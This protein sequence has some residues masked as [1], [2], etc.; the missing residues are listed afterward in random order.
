[1]DYIELAYVHLATIFPAFLIG[2]FLLFKRK[3]TRFHKQLGKVYMLLMLFT[4]SVTLLMPAE[5]GPTFLN[6]FGFIHLLSLLVFICVI[7]A[8]VA[9]RNGNIKIHKANML[10]L[11]IGGLLVAGGFTFL[12]GR[13]LNGWV[14]G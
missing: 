14:F 7:A 12:P 9:A 1:M 11:Y 13:L 8:Y 3:G 10:G 2:T 4:S 5:I 6:H